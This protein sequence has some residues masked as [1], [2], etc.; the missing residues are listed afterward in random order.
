[1]IEAEVED[2]PPPKLIFRRASNR[3]LNSI[4]LI[5]RICF[6]GESFTKRQFKYMLKSSSSIAFVAQYREELVG[7][8][9]A[10]IQRFKA[11]L[12]GRIY[13]LAV[14]PEYRGRGIARNLLLEVEREMQSLKVNQIFLEVDECN[15]VAK[16]L[17]S[18]S[19]FK[20]YRFL[21]NY[22]GQANNAFKMIKKLVY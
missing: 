1:M 15:E 9:W 6:N 7:Y 13:S 4:L 21:P 18:S 19:G 8:I 17:Y 22:Y 12:Q 20:V 11:K 2:E 10:Y 5:E 16:Q 3:D 14:K